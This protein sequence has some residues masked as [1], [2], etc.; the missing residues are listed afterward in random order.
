MIKMVSK[1]HERCDRV[2]FAQAVYP[3]TSTGLVHNSHVRL[4]FAV[5]VDRLA[6]THQMCLD[7]YK[8]NSD[9]F[10]RFL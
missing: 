3:A 4:S 10:S 5:L 1:S 8:L 9:S 7:D 6:G 2:G